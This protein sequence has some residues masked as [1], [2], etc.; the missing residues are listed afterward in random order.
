MTVCF[1]AVFLTEVQ[2]F[3]NVPIVIRCIANRSKADTPLSFD[4]PGVNHD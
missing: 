4:I 2:F 3:S 1:L